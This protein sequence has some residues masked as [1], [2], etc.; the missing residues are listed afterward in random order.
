VTFWEFLGRRKKFGGVW[1]AAGAC[2]ACSLFVLGGVE[3][4]GRGG[5]QAVQAAVTAIMFMQST[6]AVGPRKLDECSEKQL[7]MNRKHDIDY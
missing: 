7:H 6:S 5:P 2:F 4:G 1:A 3:C